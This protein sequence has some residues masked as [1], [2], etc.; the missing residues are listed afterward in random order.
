[1]TKIEEPTE[2]ERFA[3]LVDRMLAVPNGVIRNA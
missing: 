2:Y 1:V 3:A